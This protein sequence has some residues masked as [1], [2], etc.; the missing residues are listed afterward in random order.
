MILV[1]SKLA[2]P[3]LEI[4]ISKGLELSTKTSPK[5]KVVVETLILGEI[6]VPDNGTFGGELG[7][8]L[9]M[10]NLPLTTLSTSCGLGVKVTEIG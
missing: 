1:T 9:S 6:P 4:V 2:V 10:L 8:L 7:S 5:F 3:T